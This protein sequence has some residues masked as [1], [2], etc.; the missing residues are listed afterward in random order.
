[1]GINSGP[2]KDGTP[3]GKAYTLVYA[4]DGSTY[5]YRP[6]SGPRVPVREFDLRQAI[7]I[8][9]HMMTYDQLPLLVVDPETGTV[10]WSGEVLTR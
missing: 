5:A 10:M 1:M 7:S 9:D 2:A 6:R 3:N 4:E 8:A